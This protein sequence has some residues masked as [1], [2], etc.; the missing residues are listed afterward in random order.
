MGAVSP[1]AASERGGVTKGSLAVVERSGVRQR[2][3]VGRAGK[4]FGCIRAV[5][6]GRAIPAASGRDQL[7]GKKHALDHTAEYTWMT[8]IQHPAYRIKYRNQLAGWKLAMLHANL[9]M[10]FAW[11]PE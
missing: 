10:V 5:G 9:G 7:Q 4:V 2:H 11:D 6:A 8:K 3:G 1:W